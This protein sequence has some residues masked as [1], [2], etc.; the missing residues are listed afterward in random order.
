MDKHLNPPPSPLP[1][2]LPNAQQIP[3]G[4]GYQADI[5]PLLTD[6]QKA[7]DPDNK[8]TT[9]RGR[10]ST[11]LPPRGGTRVSIDSSFPISR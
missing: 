9:E 1:T 7:A 6:E 11:E 3:I 2:P 8:K 10:G 5:P 4:E